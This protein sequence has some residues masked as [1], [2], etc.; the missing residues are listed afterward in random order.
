M[1]GYDLYINDVCLDQFGSI[2]NF[3]ANRQE[4]VE[5]EKRMHF[6]YDLEASLTDEERIVD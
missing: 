2:E 4:L 1:V 3:L 5:I 6:S